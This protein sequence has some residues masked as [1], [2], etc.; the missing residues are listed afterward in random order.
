MECGIP[1]DQIGAVNWSQLHGISIKGRKYMESLLTMKAKVSVEEE[2]LSW[3]DLWAR[4]DQ[5]TIL[6]QSV[7]ETN[8]VW[9]H[10]YIMEWSLKAEVEENW[11]PPK[12]HLDQ[13]K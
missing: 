7:S 12:G 11:F 3:S 10:K 1:H 8:A 13:V 4:K 9:K 5:D 2:W 6:K